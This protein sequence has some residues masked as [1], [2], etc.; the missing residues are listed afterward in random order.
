MSPAAGRSKIIKIDTILTRPAKYILNSIIVHWKKAAG[1][2][3]IEP[4]KVEELDTAI[5]QALQDEIKDKEVV[6]FADKKELRSTIITFSIFA[7]LC[8][9]AAWL[10]YNTGLILVAGGLYR[11]G[12]PL[13]MTAIICGIIILYVSLK[14]IVTYFKQDPTKP[15]AI[16]NKDGIKMLPSKHISWQEVDSITKNDQSHFVHVNLKGKSTFSSSL[17]FDHINLSS[18]ELAEILEKCHK[19]YSSISNRN[20]LSKN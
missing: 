16:I 2:P 19:A 9:I 4:E 12:M 5:R 1:I 20:K 15:L 11:K 7:S 6:V 13:W 3:E 17:T 8:F 10:T 14:Y 18:Q